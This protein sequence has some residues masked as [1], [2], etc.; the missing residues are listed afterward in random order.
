[1]KNTSPAMK[2]RLVNVAS[3]GQLVPGRALLEITSQNDIAYNASWHVVTREGRLVSGFMTERVTIV[4]VA[5]P[6]FRARISIQADRVEEEYIELT[7]RYE[8]VHSPELGNPPHLSGR[9]TLPYRYSEV[10][11]TSRLVR[12]SSIE[13]SECV[14]GTGLLI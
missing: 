10:G 4:P 8:S 12:W 9:I 1:M 14:T 2:A 11:C 5:T 3:D 13:R 6:V 7:V